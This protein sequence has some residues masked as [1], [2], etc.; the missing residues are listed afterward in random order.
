MGGFYGN[1]GNPLEKSM[2]NEMEIRVEQEVA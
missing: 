1:H 2:D